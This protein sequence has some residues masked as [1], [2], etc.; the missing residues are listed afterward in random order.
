MKDLP[1]KIRRLREL[2]N[3]SQEYLADRLGISRRT[4]GKIEAGKTR[5][6]TNRLAHIATIFNCPVEAMILYP[7]EEIY[8]QFIYKNP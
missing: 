3:L 4:Y 6:T 7:A 1:Q 2:Q 5:I 8:M